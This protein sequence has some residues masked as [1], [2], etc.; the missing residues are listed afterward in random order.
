[1]KDAQAIEKMIQ[2]APSGP[3]KD[4]LLARLAILEAAAKNPNLLPAYLL[5]PPIGQ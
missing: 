3:M 2:A 5:L 1:L 4:Q